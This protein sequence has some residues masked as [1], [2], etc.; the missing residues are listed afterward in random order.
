M[1]FKFFNQPKTV[2]NGQ[3]LALIEVQNTQI[4]SKNL[5]RVLTLQGLCASRGIP[6]AARHPNGPGM[7]SAPL[8]LALML[9]RFGTVNFFLVVRTGPADLF[10]SLCEYL[11]ATELCRMPL[12]EQMPCRVKTATLLPLHLLIFDER[13]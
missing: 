12:R 2:E 13:A 5:N 6:Q 9:V 3:V 7:V 10:T 1:L 8:F 4:E 11:H